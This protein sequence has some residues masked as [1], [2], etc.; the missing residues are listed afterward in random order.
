MEDSSFSSLCHFSPS[1]PVSSETAEAS[2]AAPWPPSLAHTSN[3]VRLQQIIAG[4]G[5][6][7]A[8]ADGR[9]RARFFDRTVL[10]LTG[11]HSNSAEERQGATGVLC[12]AVELLLPHGYRLQKRV[13]VETPQSP[14]F[15]DW[16]Q[17]LGDA[18]H[19]Y[20]SLTI[21]NEGSLLQQYVKPTV[22]F[23]RWAAHSQRDR[24]HKARKQALLET[25][26][27]WHTGASAP[28]N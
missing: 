22:E 27:K 5:V 8:F 1:S 6:F 19:T 11:T 28:T 16:D 4:V 20:T 3:S 21:Q 15:V 17:D 26:V 7:V 9:V 13:N 14:F 23:G 24:Y 10:G 2:A 25:L 18:T 12:C